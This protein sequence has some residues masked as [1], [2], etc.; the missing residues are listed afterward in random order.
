MFDFRT[1]PFPSQ[2]PGP[3]LRKSSRAEA[4]SSFPTDC[5]IWLS[6]SYLSICAL[7][8][9]HDFATILSRRFVQGQ[10]QG[11][12]RTVQFN[13]PGTPLSLKNGH[14]GRVPVAE[15]HQRQT[16][17]GVSLHCSSS[18]GQSTPLSIGSLCT[19][20]ITWSLLLTAES[21][22]DAGNLPTTR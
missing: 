11:S 12:F 7:R 1:V 20:S 3:D 16:A 18:Q 15:V 19:D 6:S 2:F 21:S 22:R 14:N 8:I 9:A 5:Q 10:G 13:S 17:G 4:S